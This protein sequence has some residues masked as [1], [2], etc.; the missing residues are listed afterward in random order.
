MPMAEPLLLPEQSDLLASLVTLARQSPE[1]VGT[2]T[3]VQH[4][5]GIAIA[6]ARRVELEDASMPNLRVLAEA[7]LVGMAEIGA[8]MW[9][10]WVTPHGFAYDQRRRS[11]FGQPLVGLQGE[12]VNYLETDDF[13][14]RHPA[15]HRAWKRAMASLWTQDSEQHIS[16]IGHDCREA[17]QAFTTELLTLTGVTSA[18]TDTSHTKNRI[19]TALFGRHEQSG[20]S[21]P[22]LEALIDYVDALIPAIQQA[23][24]AGQKQGQPLV[25]EDARRIVFL[26]GLAM[27]E[28]DR[29]VRNPADLAG[30]RRR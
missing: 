25:W 27:Y 21:T 2:F 4:L 3:V 13:V 28:L 8:Q 12:V 29:A 18:D 15:A 20:T 19:R 30:E 16:S 7:R 17:L 1:E 6:S 26:T 9:Q 11:G 23:E 24:H 10:L 22:S 5:M 14:A